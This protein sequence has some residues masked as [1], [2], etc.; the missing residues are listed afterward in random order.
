MS[1]LRA[2]DPGT[3]GA[4]TGGQVFLALMLTVTVG[5]ILIVSWISPGSTEARW[6]CWVLCTIGTRA[7]LSEKLSCASM[8]RRSWRREQT[9]W[10]LY[11]CR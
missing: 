3:M 5:G 4:D 2:L 11:P 7:V 6:L 10:M 9:I 8:A 1:L